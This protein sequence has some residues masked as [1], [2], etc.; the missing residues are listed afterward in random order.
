MSQFAIRLTGLAFRLRRGVGRYG[1]IGSVREAANRILSHSDEH[2]WFVLDLDRL[3]RL[4][5]PNGY[6]LRRGTE[7]DL[8]VVRELRAL[9][10][11]EARKRL[12]NQVQVWLVVHGSEP[13]FVCLVFPR[14]FPTEGS[15]EGELELPAGVAA[16]G[17]LVTNPAHAGDGL[18][19]A[20][21]TAVAE[22][23][24]AQGFAVLVAKVGVGNPGL[25]GVL[26]QAGFRPACVMQ[27]QRRGF[28]TRVTFRDTGAT[29]TATEDRIRAELAR[30]LTTSTSKTAGA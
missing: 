26:E 22:E 29:L 25:Q 12:A 8:E 6:R 18:A 10:V 17:N 9:P 13:A 19:P 2:V 7:A 27:R 11:R 15:R 28:R 20:A 24:K 21:Q 4:P 14:S 5:L 30:L 23:L 16:L 3:E 1:A